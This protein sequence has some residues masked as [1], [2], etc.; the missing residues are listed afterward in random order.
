MAADNGAAMTSKWRIL[1]LMDQEYS[2]HSNT[3]MVNLAWVD[4]GCVYVF[5]ATLT[6]PYHTLVE[7]LQCFSKCTAVMVQ[8]Y[9]V[10]TTVQYLYCTGT[11][12]GA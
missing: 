9:S 6:V 1:Q 11:L 3:E 10:V 2:V 7:K 12:D 5:N 8:S 4:Y